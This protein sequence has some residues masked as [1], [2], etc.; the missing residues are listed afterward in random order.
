MAVSSCS[1]QVHEKQSAKLSI[2]F[3][4]NREE[5]WQKRHPGCY[6]LE[7][8]GITWAAKGMEDAEPSARSK[9]CRVARACQSLPLQTSWWRVLW[10][11]RILEH[12]Q[13]LSLNLGENQAF[14]LWGPLQVLEIV[15]QRKPG[16]IALC[17]GVAS[18]TT[19][20]LYILQ[21]FLNACCLVD[22]FQTVKW[23]KT[24]TFE[25]LPNY[26]HGTKYC[27]ILKISGPCQRLWLVHFLP[28]QH[29]ILYSLVLF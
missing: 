28:S 29:H 15:K 8:F 2:L 3:P 14:F 9:P 27:E 25:Q 13:S 18:C 5:S 11:F 16:F 7:S 10:N 1:G 24:G 19:A 26:K 22:T 4:G 20:P 12:H 23:H 17:L 6:K 21:R